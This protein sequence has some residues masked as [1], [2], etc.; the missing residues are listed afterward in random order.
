MN[1]TL[2]KKIL[3]LITFKYKKSIK[4]EKK[5]NLY[6]ICCEN[7]GNLAFTTTSVGQQQDSIKINTFFLLTI[8]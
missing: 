3:V 6:C 5:L 1:A 2:Q 7:L 8:L 4:L